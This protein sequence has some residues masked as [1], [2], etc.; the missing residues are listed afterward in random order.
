MNRDNEASMTRQLR[1]RENNYLVEFTL[2][3]I[4]VQIKGK[5]HNLIEREE[6]STMDED[7]MLREWVKNGGGFCDGWMTN[8]VA[9]MEEFVWCL[10]GWVAKDEDGDVE[11]DDDVNEKRWQS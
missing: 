3:A 10:D 7:N 8:N 5:W 2:L 11:D 1:S 9:E 4:L 6:N